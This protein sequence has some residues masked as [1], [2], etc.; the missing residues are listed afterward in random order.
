MLQY[1]AHP[2]INCY[3]TTIINLKDGSFLL[4][5]RINWDITESL[6]LVAG[7]DIPIGS[8]G[9]EFGELEFDNSDTSWGQGR[10]VYLLLTWY[11]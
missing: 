8:E 6:Q 11:F 3:L 7:F 10:Q 1:E 4:Q 5:P 9:E 2:L